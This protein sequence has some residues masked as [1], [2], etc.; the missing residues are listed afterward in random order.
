MKIRYL[1]KI[2]IIFS[3][4]PLLSCGGFF[5]GD[6]NNDGIPLNERAP[7]TERGL[8]IRS[9][10]N[11][12]DLNNEGNFR[13][14]L[15]TNPGR[16]VTITVNHTELSGNS[17][18]EPLAFLI[19]PENFESGVPV[20]IK[21]VCDALDDN[22]TFLLSFSTT[23]GYNYPSAMQYL[24]PSFTDGDNSTMER[25]TKSDGS[26]ADNLTGIIYDASKIGYRTSQPFTTEA[27]GNSTIYLRLCKKPT[28]NTTVNLSVSDP[29]EAQLS[30]NSVIFSTGNWS[31]EVP[32]NVMGLDDNEIDID[33]EYYIEASSSGYPTETIKLKNIDNE[34]AQFV[35]SVSSISS[36]Q[37][38]NTG[39]FTVQLSSKPTSNVTLPLSVRDTPSGQSSTQVTISPTS[40][41]FTTANYS[42]AQTV[43]VTATN[44]AT[45]EGLMN[46]YLYMGPASTSDNSYSN[47]P[48][49][50]LLGTIYD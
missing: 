49:K 36:I 14:G 21:G 28:S 38:G 35:S 31:T 4:T 37:E 9:L 26:Y 30:T 41:S 44:D 23:G 48:A 29:S 6:E 19:T 2:L 1:Y 15:S 47:L 17:T 13:V 25:G 43:T 46:Y 42:A 33:T 11:T 3:M 32:V 45:S 34:T 18:I 5:E 20:T 24:D 39:T 27:S 22:A 7:T 40:L 10:S 8:V 16:N 50:I 12:L